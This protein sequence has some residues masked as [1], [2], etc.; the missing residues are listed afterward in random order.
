MFTPM[1]CRTT[2]NGTM[3]CLGTPL[4]SDDENVD[5]VPPFPSWPEFDRSENHG[6]MTHKRT[7]GCSEVP[8][9]TKAWG[10][11]SHDDGEHVDHEGSQN[12][13]AA[14]MFW[15][16]QELKQLR[17]TLEQRAQQCPRMPEFFNEPFQ[18]KYSQTSVGAE[19]F[20]SAVTEMCTPPPP[21]P[22]VGPV[23]GRALAQ[24][25]EVGGEGVERLRGIPITLPKLLDVTEPKS[26]LGAGDWLSEIQPLIT[27]VSENARAWWQTVM[28][29]ANRTYH[30]WLAAG[31][32]EKLQVTPNVMATEAFSRLESR[33]V[34]MLLGSLPATLEQEVIVALREVTCVQI[35]FRIFKQYRPGG[36]NERAATLSSLTRTASAKAPT[37]AVEDCELGTGTC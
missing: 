3:V 15:L 11:R 34:S 33:V 23:R 27:D 5:Q 10:S 28:D 2:L 36:L 26:A 12:A 13:Q 21:P 30:M 18:R 35:I 14:K 37:E 7:L 20:R 32:L 17:E 1:E 9:Q 22:P 31:P 19:V 24:V 4:P 6:V 16:E 29:E 25:E 8:R